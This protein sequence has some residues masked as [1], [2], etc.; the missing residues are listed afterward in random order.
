MHARLGP[1]RDWY[2]HDMSV[3]PAGIVTTK[4]FSRISLIKPLRGWRFRLPPAQL[5]TAHSLDPID[6][7]HPQLL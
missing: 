6:I 4:Y 5:K 1:P 2:L 3:V 7:E